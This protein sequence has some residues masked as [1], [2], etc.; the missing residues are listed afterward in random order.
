VLWENNALIG[1]VGDSRIYRQRNHYLEQLTVD[2]TEAQSM[3]EKGYRVHVP[4]DAVDS[5]TDENWRVG[6]K[7][8]DK[9]G[10]IITSTEAVIYQI[11]KEAGTKEF[12]KMLKIIR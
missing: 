2:Q 3:L 8:M 9:A 4:R 7:L 1:H 10:A 5:R 11:L 6:L 12:K